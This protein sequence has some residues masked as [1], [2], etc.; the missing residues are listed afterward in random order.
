MI[1]NLAL[2]VL[3]LVAIAGA[4]VAL[5]WF[6]T[7]PMNRGRHRSDRPVRFN[8]TRHRSG[9]ARPAPGRHTVI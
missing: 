2:A 3:A 4:V 5:F 7:P 9:G 6:S 8:V 1:V